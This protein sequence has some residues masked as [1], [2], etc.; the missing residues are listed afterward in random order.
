MEHG[1][2]LGAEEERLDESGVVPDAARV[3]LRDVELGDELGGG[4]ERRKDG[5]GALATDLVYEGA[6]ET[7]YEIK[8]T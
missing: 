6:A 2:R 5:N 8:W 1:K 4:H 3:A 7:Y